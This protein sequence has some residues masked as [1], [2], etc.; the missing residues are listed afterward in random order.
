MA[1]VAVFVAFFVER[2]ILG[3]QIKLFGQAPRAARFAG[4]SEGRVIAGCLLISSISRASVFL[5]W[6]GQS[7]SWFPPYPSDTV[8]RHH[9]RVFRA[10]SPGRHIVGWHCHGT[11]SSAA[12]QRS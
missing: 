10:A 11:D 7:V 4:F 8:Y 5:K 9:R 1:L 6:Q 12:I 2:H 3:V